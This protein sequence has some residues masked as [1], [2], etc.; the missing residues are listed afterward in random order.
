MLI[1][2]RRVSQGGFLATHPAQSFLG[3]CSTPSYSLGQDLTVPPPQVKVLTW[4]ARHHIRHILFWG[5]FRI[6][7]ACTSST[8]KAI[9]CWRLLIC[10]VL[11]TSIQQG[12]SSASACQ[13]PGILI[14]PTCFANKPMVK[15]PYDRSQA[16][17]STTSETFLTRRGNVR[18]CTDNP[19]LSI[20]GV[21]KRTAAIG[22]VVHVHCLSGVLLPACSRACLFNTQRNTYPLA[23]QDSHTNTLNNLTASLQIRQ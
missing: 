17:S 21:G 10:D 1:D 6:G 4:S 8:R 15:R 22:T 5:T 9:G 14:A 11:C 18:A 16:R 2:L 3:L 23:Q 7:N 13:S 19:S 20:M 12:L